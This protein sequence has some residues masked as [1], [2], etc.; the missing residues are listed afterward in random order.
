MK[1]VILIILILTVKLFSQHLPLKIGNQ[2]HY[3]GGL[4]PYD[5]YLAIATDT[6]KIND[7]LYFKIECRDAYTETITRI[8]YDR[9]EGDSLYFRLTNET[10]VLI[11]NFKVDSG[12][13]RVVPVEQD[14]SCFIISVYHRDPYV[15]WGISTECLYIRSGVCCPEVSPDTSWGWGGDLYLANFGCLDCQDG[16]LMGAV[17]DGTEY[18]NLYPLPV[19]LISFTAGLDD[20]MVKLK[21]QTAT[22]IN[23]L[24]FG[25]FRK[26]S[27]PDA[28]F[29]QIVF[30]PGVGTTMENQNYSYNDIT[31]F[32]GKVFY[33]L[34]QYDFDGT[35]KI[36]GNLELNSNTTVNDFVLYQN[37]PNPFN[38]VTTIN[39]Q[40]PTADF[41]VLKIFNSLGKEIKT[42]V[43]EYQKEGLHTINFD[44]SE[45][46]SGVYFY[47]ISS[48]NFISTKKMVVIK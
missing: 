48:G 29:K 30:I 25:L 19:E 17:I 46:S 32:S 12:M 21:W 13:T 10:E 40:I 7:K 2:W 5:P 3:A 4:S 16:L 38:P 8:T 42:I 35:S 23:N 18:G 26:E 6:I 44:A 37:H 27:A 41:V 47:Q 20:N 43:N 34:V 39:Y 1:K 33:R 31:S 45:I 24:G 15:L 14:T 22:E 9:L 28:E 36:I 11:W